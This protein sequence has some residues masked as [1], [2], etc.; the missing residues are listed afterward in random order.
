MEH[1]SRR[2]LSNKAEAAFESRARQ[3]GWSVTKRGWP[4]FIC[5]LPD[6]KVIVVEVKPTGPTGRPG[7]VK[8]IQAKVMEWLAEQGVRCFVSDGKVLVPYSRSEHAPV[9]GR[10]QR[11]PRS[12]PNRIGGLGGSRPTR[13]EPFTFVG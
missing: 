8:A 7:R 3:N 11:H 2:V 1:N 4:D 5:E 9:P 6:G 10:R 12:K 13:A